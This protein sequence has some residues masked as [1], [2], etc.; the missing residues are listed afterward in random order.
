M[1]A[2]THLFTVYGCIVLYYLYSYNYA[3]MCCSY[4]NVNH[5]SISPMEYIIRNA[6]ASYAT[7]SLYQWNKWFKVNICS[8]R[9]PTIYTYEWT[10]S[11]CTLEDRRVWDEQGVQVFAILIYYRDTY[12]NIYVTFIAASLVCLITLAIKKQL[13]QYILKSLTYSGRHWSPK[14]DGVIRFLFDYTVFPQIYA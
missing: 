5:I 12:L 14:Y 2:S 7:F 10:A 4:F 11:S 1:Y 3:V 9:L 6:N 13:L 8:T